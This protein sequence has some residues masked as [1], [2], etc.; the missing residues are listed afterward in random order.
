[1]FEVKKELRYK[2]DKINRLRL[3]RNSEKAVVAEWSKA[4]DSKSNSLWERRFESYQL[5]YFFTFLSLHLFFISLSSLFLI[6]VHS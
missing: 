3:S 4:F 1:M 6:P 5:R 2:I